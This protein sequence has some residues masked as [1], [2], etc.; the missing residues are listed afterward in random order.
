MKIKTFIFCAVAA[1]MMAACAETRTGNAISVDELALTIEQMQDGDTLSV[2]GFCSDVCGHGSSHITLVGEDT[3]QMI[4]AVA[5][6]S[7]GSFSDEIKYQYVT[8]NCILKEQ[9]VDKEFLNDWEYRLDESLKGPQANPEAVAMLKE[10]I[11]MLRDSIDARF[12][13]CGKN[14][15]SNYTLLVTSYEADK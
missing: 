1:V 3:T 11:V 8:V 9:K 7:L 5:D 6:K 15:W 10:Q 2:R 12:A 13:R 4:A 14:Y